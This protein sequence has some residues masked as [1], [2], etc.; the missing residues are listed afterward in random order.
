VILATAPHAR[1][2]S[3]LVQ[4]LG[5]EGCLLIVAAAFE[6]MEIN[7]IDLISRVARVQGWASG[8][9]SDSADAMAFAVKHGV[10]PMIERFPLADAS[11][12]LEAMMKGTVRFRAVLD[13]APL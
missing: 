5:V 2:I 4:G 12:G 13:V 7:G 10:H 8:T 11:R 1:S 6:P 9:A 3:A